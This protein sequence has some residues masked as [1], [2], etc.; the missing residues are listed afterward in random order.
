MANL[1][2]EMNRGAKAE[3]LLN[4]EM[5]KEALEH[6]E[7][8]ILEKWKTSPVVDKDGQHE[9]RL[10]LKCHQEFKKFLEDAINTG[11]L[12]SFQAEHESRMYKMRKA[13]RLA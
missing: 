13:F 12:A 9:L 1:P 11:K 8:Q 10:M 5:F 2:N 7:S 6:V 4:N 3:A